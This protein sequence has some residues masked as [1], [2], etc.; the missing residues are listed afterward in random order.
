MSIKNI[1]GDQQV[2]VDFIKSIYI[3]DLELFDKCSIENPISHLTT[4]HDQNKNDKNS[5]RKN[6]KA[7]SC[8]NFQN[9]F[10]NMLEPSDNKLAMKLFGSKKGVLKEKLRQK[11]AGH[12]VIHPCSN[13]M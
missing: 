11:N 5:E 13:F 10:S 3:E 2:T 9:C 6:T 7:K 1:N 12:W 4:N 8:F